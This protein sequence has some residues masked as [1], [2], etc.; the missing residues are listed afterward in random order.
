V[1][2]A[3]FD[4]GPEWRFRAR[5]VLAEFEATRLPSWLGGRVVSDNRAKTRARR[6]VARSYAAVCGDAETGERGLVG[7][8]AADP[9]REAEAEPFSEETET[10][11]RC[12]Y[13]FRFAVAVDPA[14]GR[15]TWPD[16]GA[17]RATVRE[18]L[19]DEIDAALAGATD[20]GARVTVECAGP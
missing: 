9:R 1:V 2:A 10:G 12:G 3:V 13:E 17:D 19:V 8:F 7:A 4:D 15:A 20:R 11:V 14:D 18:A 5:A 16:P 6:A